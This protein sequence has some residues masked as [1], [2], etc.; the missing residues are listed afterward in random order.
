MNPEA[1]FVIWLIC[2]GEMTNTSFLWTF[3]AFSTMSDSFLMMWIP[4]QGQYGNH[5][6]GLTG[7][8]FWREQV[9]G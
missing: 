8:W 5:E 4:V 1:F 7:R 3:F 2:P 6:R 9:G